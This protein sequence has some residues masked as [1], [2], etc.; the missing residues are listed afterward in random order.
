MGD[1]TA[2]A[3]HLLS[4]LRQRVW[5]RAIAWPVYPAKPYSTMEKSAQRLSLFRLMLTQRGWQNVQLF[6]LFGHGA[7]RHLDVAH[8]EQISQFLIGERRCLLLH[9]FLDNVF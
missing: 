1:N 9:Q 7:A 2:M 4:L 3:R 6:V 5:R 8:L